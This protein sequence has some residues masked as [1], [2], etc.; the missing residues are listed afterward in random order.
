M[1]V[2]TEEA[3]CKTGGMLSKPKQKSGRFGFKPQGYEM[4]HML[5][6]NFSYETT[7]IEI[8]IQLNYWSYTDL[9]Y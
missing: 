3:S 7:I 9:M 1:A 2:R 6:M 4:N 8:H 5:Q